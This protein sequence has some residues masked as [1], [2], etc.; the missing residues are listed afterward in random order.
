MARMKINIRNR[1]SYKVKIVSMVVGFT[2]YTR[3]CDT[4]VWHTPLVSKGGVR[5]NLSLDSCI[6]CKAI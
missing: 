6:L 2:G 4:H 3:M 1:L 5:V